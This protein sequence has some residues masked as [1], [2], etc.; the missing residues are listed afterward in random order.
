MINKYSCVQFKYSSNTLKSK[1][2]KNDLKF[3]YSQWI[4]KNC[5]TNTVKE[6]EKYKHL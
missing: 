6:N 4:D 2:D 5:L 1:Q 3:Q